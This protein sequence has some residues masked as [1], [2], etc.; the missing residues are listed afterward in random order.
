MYG[1]MQYEV[2]A[3][4]KKSDKGSVY[5]AK[6]EEYDFP[7]I[8]KQLKRGNRK[9]YEALQAL[10]NEYIPQIYHL[11]ENEDGLLVAEEYIEGELLSEYLTEHVLTE[12]Q[13]ISIAR[14]LCDGLEK[15]HSCNPPVIHR[16]IKPSNIIVTSDGRVKII[17]FDSARLYKAD[18]DGD[19]RLL[20]T[21]NYAAPEQYGY[22]QTDC[23]SD[24]YSLGVV[25]GKFPVFSLQKKNRLWKKMVEKCTLFAP[26]SRYQSVEDVERELKKIEATGMKGVKS[27]GVAVFF[28]LLGIAGFLLITDDG[29]REARTQVGT[30][31]PEPVSGLSPA[32]VSESTPS[33]SPTPVLEPSPSPSPT[34]VSEPTPS[35]SPTPRL[36]PTPEAEQIARL[37][38]DVMPEPTSALLPLDLG[39]IVVRRTYADCGLPSKPENCPE[40]RVSEEDLIQVAV[41]KK[42]IANS[43]AYV[44]Y[45]FK[46]R[47]QKADLL[48]YNTLLDDARESFIGVKLYSYQTSEWMRLSGVQA[49]EKDGICHIDGRFMD[50]LE[51]GFYQLVMQMRF[52]G[53]KGI[54]EHSVYV[55]VAESD[56]FQ[57]FNFCVENN[58][59]EYRGEKGVTLHS[60][61]KNDCAERIVSV[62][63]EW[64]DSMD[65]S[66]YK[67]LYDGRAVE[68]SESLLENFM[69]NGELRV[70]L[71]LSDNSKELLTIKVL[72]D[73]P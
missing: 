47:M 53:D 66:L 61:I 24:I 56:E 43:K 20:G 13:Y 23:R 71:E 26:E 11:E 27:I 60:T 36:S 38:P 62:Q 4:I 70:W 45:Y 65:S 57:G 55:Y 1:K 39:E 33:L 68:F 48:T 46:D 7:V 17:D 3:I 64:G 51:D 32:P 10:K 37:T 2:I 19:T 6:V 21:E 15:L 41:L 5:L 49:M 22:S 18:A 8:V 54:R 44:Q 31:S 69:E 9:V 52:E 59:L 30:L 67:I 58:C 12:T 34:P 50:E 40:C 72:S 63:W 28:L 42:K 73:L 16:D 29:A 25:L 14:Q 35:P